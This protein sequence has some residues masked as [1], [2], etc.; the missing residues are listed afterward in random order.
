MASA[1]WKGGD[2]TGPIGIAVGSLIVGVA[3]LG[4]KYLAYALTGSIA[5]YSDALESLVN[6]ATAVVALF[7][8]RLSVQP[9]DRNHPYGHHKIE[10]FSAVFAGALIMVAAGMI[11]FEAW[12]GIRAPRAIEAPVPGLLLSA[13]ASVVNAWWSYTL[14]RQGRA[15]RSPALVADGKHLMTD[16]VTSAGVTL[17]I[18]LAVL[19]GWMILDPLMAAFVAVNI[20]WSG[21]Q[22]IRDSLGGLMDEGLPEETLA[23]I[24][25]AIE[26]GADGGAIE[27]HD[28]RARTSGPATFVDF[29]MVVPGAMA[30]SEAHEICDRIEHAIKETTADA[31]VTIHVE[32]EEKAKLDPD[33]PGLAIATKG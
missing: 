12:E 20:L 7:A 22:V 26:R 24:L 5:L 18:V 8:V 32:P 27:V 30:V 1:F 9:A 16:V 31:L 3:V 4:V 11:L 25:E 19:S 29:H 6:V 33:V 23:P 21:W 14:I 10:Y 2:M 13:L 28:L 15:L 17:G